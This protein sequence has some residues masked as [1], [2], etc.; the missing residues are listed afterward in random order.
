GWRIYHRHDE[1]EITGIIL[2][3][4]GGLRIPDDVREVMRQ[5]ARSKDPRDAQRLAGYRGYEAM[6]HKRRRPARPSRTPAHSAPP[7]P[8]RPLAPPALPA[9]RGNELQP[10]IGEASGDD[11]SF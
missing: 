5:L 4:N 8:A 10:R 3:R 7:R 1:P 2:G 6:I 11:I 9:V